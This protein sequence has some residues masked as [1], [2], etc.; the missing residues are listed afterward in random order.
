MLEAIQRVAAIRPNGERSGATYS[1]GRH[2]KL[3][4][5]G[6]FSTDFNN[7]KNHVDL[8]KGEDSFGVVSLCVTLVELLDVNVNFVIFNINIYRL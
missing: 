1:I 8:E 7:T 2:R 6:M 3:C 4:F 5:L